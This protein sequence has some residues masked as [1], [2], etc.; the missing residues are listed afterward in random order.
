MVF[1]VPVRVCVCQSVM[2]VLVAVLD[3][4][5]WLRLPGVGMMVMRVVMR[6]LVRVSERVVLMR[7]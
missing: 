7:M 2:S 1:I 5:R 3:A 4:R 6:M